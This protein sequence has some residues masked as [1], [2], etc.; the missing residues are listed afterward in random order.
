MTVII[1]LNFTICRKISFAYVPVRRANL[2]FDFGDGDL[3]FIRY[4]CVILLVCKARVTIAWEGGLETC[5]VQRD[6]TDR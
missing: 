6:Q 5:S 3:R 4:D 2:I 1:P